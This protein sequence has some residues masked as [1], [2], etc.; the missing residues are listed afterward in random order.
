MFFDFTGAGATL[1][2]PAKLAI[3]MAI[4]AFSVEASR[5][6]RLSAGP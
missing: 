1:A 3:D 5:D 2:V 4:V 6:R